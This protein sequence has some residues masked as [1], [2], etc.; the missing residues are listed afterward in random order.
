MWHPQAADWQ[1][2]DRG[3]HGHGYRETQRSLVLHW[4]RWPQQ[5]P[6]LERTRERRQWRRRAART[7]GK[8]A[9]MAVGLHP[10][11]AQSGGRTVTAAVV[12]QCQTRSQ[13]VGQ[14]L[15]A[16]PKRVKEAKIKQHSYGNNF[17]GQTSSLCNVYSSIKTVHKKHIYA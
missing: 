13:S 14:Y 8:C 12:L 15:L 17:S 7:D 6:C 16:L 10:P 9:R 2:I 1:P 4:I 11:V 5:K 3:V